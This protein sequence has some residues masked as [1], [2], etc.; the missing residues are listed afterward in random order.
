MKAKIKELFKKI[1][2]LLKRNVQKLEY[3]K[4][5]DS[6][7]MPEYIESVKKLANT[8]ISRSP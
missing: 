2:S 5:I 7:D 1:T 8:H 4:T 6:D 3:T